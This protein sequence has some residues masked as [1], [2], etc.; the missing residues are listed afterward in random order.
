MR[1]LLSFEGRARRRDWWIITLSLMAAQMLVSA[2]LWSTT[3]T[4]YEGPILGGW[5]AGY[6]VEYSV[7]VLALWPTLAVNVR[8]AH[9][10]GK[11]GI[12]AVVAQLALF[13]LSFVAT[14]EGMFPPT[15]ATGLAAMWVMLPCSLYLLFRLGLADG[16]PGPNRFGPSPKYDGERVA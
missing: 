2:S 16:T 10:R 8:R 13:G 14:A 6:T 5:S 11:S 1:R 7:A 4:L 15:T 12:P 3:P 9:D